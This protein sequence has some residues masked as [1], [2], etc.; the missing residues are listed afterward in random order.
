MILQYPT[1]CFGYCKA[2]TPTVM[3]TPPCFP[4]C[5]AAAA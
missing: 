5:Q 3:V 4:M 1:R 2:N